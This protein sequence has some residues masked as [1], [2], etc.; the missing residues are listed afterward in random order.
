MSERIKHACSVDSGIHNN[1]KQK[2]VNLVGE[3]CLI[4][5]TIAD[6]K[7]ECLWDTGS[8]VALI[9]KGWIHENLRVQPEIFQLADLLEVEAVGGSSIP[10]DG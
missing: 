8:Q 3:R 2:I 5:A 6:V 10:Y 9:S 4:D 1:Q 7:T